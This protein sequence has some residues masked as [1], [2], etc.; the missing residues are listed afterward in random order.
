MHRYNAGPRDG[1]AIDECRGVHVLGV[2]ATPER[3]DGQ[4]LGVLAGGFFDSMVIGPAVRELVAEGYLSQPV[5][6]APPTPDLSGL[7]SQAGDYAKAEAAASVD[8]PTITGSAVEHYRRHCNGAPALAFC[9]TVAHADHV[10]QTFGRAGYQAASIDGTLDGG[11]RASRIDD[12]ANGRLNVL[13]SCEIVSEG[14]D[15]PVV[16]CAI[17]LRPTQSLGLYLQQ[18]GR[19]LRPYPGK[20]RATILDHVGNCRRHGLPDDD[21]EWDLNASKR[22]KRERDT[23]ATL[24]IR[25]CEMC[26]HI[27]RPAP[28]CPKCG[29]ANVRPAARP[30]EVPGELEKVTAAKPEEERKRAEAKFLEELRELRELRE[31]GRRRGY[32]PGWAIHIW[33]AR[34]KRRA[35]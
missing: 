29:H 34:K 14:T 9:V 27:Y 26:Y 35:G 5:V 7:R 20:E 23:E 18:A 31:L 4:G 3:L 11:T 1:E 15:I 25:Q 19:A 16:A 6:Y 22:S 12:L 33:N 13:T 17:L 21:R 28:T 24:P 8:K 10:A 2:T 32:K 30:E